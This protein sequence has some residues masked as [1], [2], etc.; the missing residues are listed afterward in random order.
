MAASHGKNFPADFGGWK[1]RTEWL[2]GEGTLIH[3]GNARTVRLTRARNVPEWRWIVAATH[4]AA[5]LV[6]AG[7]PAATSASGGWVISYRCGLSGIPVL[8]ERVHFPKAFP[9][10]IVHPDAAGTDIVDPAMDSNRALGKAA[11]HRCVGPE[12]AKL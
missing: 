5:A 1:G 9:V 12:M 8:F 2:Y 3:S 7:R 4:F 10:F 11:C 6:E